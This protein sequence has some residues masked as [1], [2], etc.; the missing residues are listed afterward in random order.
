MISILN[1][2]YITGFILW[3]FTIPFAIY[4][5]YHDGNEEFKKNKIYYTSSL[6]IISPNGIENY[7]IFMYSCMYCLIYYLFCLLLGTLINLYFYLY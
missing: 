4:K 7:T 5:G 2:I 6:V 1:Q 3:L